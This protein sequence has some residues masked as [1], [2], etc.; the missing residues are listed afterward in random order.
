MH[1]HRGPKD[2]NEGSLLVDNRCHPHAGV[3][4]TLLSHAYL[5]VPRIG[6]SSKASIFDGSIISFWYAL[7]SSA[8]EDREPY[9]HGA[10]THRYASQSHRHAYMCVRASF[11]ATTILLTEEHTWCS[12]I[13]CYGHSVFF[14]PRSVRGKRSN[15]DAKVLNA[16]CPA[17]LY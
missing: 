15:A 13:I 12:I 7:V 10:E 17:H 1:S 5:P 6:P 3:V 14:S 9:T 2:K 11:V 4:M 16:P 8:P